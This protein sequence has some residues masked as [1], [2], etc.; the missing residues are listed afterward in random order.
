MIKDVY[1][2]FRALPLWVQ[3]WVFAILVPVNLV[4][5]FF[6]TQPYG[7]LVALLA[8]G[9][10][11]P[12]AFLIFF[13]RG[14]SKA[15]S[16]PHILIWTPLIFVIWNALSG[17]EGLSPAY[18]TYL[19]VLLAINLISLAFDFPDTWRWYRGERAVAGK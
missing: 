7:V 9:G 5:M 8:V 13:E 6:W 2:S 1:D 15:M 3:I 11:S 17:A 19:Q 16:I 12:N 14:F 4:S 18:V 10:M